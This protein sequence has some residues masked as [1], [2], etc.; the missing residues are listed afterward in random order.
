MANADDRRFVKVIAGSVAGP[1]SMRSSGFE[2][3][4]RKRTCG[5]SP[6]D[7]SAA[8]GPAGESDH[9]KLAPE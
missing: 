3:L 1:A 2:T 6:K 7:S 5:S 8:A 4:P 9:A